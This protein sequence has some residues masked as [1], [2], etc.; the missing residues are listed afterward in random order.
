[1]MDLAPV[2]RQ[3]LDQNDIHGTIILITDD[4][5][6]QSRVIQASR[7]IHDTVMMKGLARIIFEM[8]KGNKNVLDQIILN[9]VRTIGL[10]CDMIE[11]L[12]KNN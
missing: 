2:L 4:H 8:K 11:D 10:T 9:C 1:M 12:G 5:D 3:L 7:E 6:G